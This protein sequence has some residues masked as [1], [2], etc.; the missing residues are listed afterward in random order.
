MLKIKIIEQ[1]NYSKVCSTA[2]ILK[3]ETITRLEGTEQPFPSKYS[4]QTGEKK[5]IVPFSENPDDQKSIWRFLNHSCSP[6]SYFDLEKMSLIAFRDIAEEE[7]ITYHYCSTEFDMALPF[8]CLCG[9]K[10]C[11]GEIK[12][13]RYLSEE[14]KNAIMSVSASHLKITE[15]LHT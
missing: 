13:Y 5:H 10:N 1:K 2:K 7:E 3:E 15:T 14:K 8:Q 6:N 11:L 12:G 9:S 4:I